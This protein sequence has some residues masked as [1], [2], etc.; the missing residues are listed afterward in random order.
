[1]NTKDYH[2][3]HF[4]PAKA[5]ELGPWADAA[6][7]NWGMLYDHFVKQP[8]EHLH[9]TREAITQMQRRGGH[10]DHEQ[11]VLAN[12][13]QELAHLLEIRAAK[14]AGVPYR[15]PLELEGLAKTPCPADPAAALLWMRQSRG[16]VLRLEW[17][18]KAAE[19]DW[20]WEHFV[21]VVMP[22][23]REAL[24]AFAAATDPLLHRQAHIL[25]RWLA[26][27]L[28]WSQ[29]GGQPELL[30]PLAR[31]LASFVLAHQVEYEPQWRTH[32]ANDI[33]LW[34]QK[35]GIDL[36]IAHGGKVVLVGALRETCQRPRVGWAQQAGARG[37][38]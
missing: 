8:D 22:W 16:I 23:A 35:T 1:M 10:S 38:A 15:L 20:D 28:I 13:N 36:G 14:Q 32:I 17:R 34:E 6:L 29:E 24:P 26:T 25:P 7:G 4:D 30:E 37:C 2:R 5:R 33:D 18:L 12:F 19:H 11:H 9:A 31:K 27:W 21:G 3:K